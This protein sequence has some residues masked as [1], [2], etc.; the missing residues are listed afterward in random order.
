MKP[1]LVLLL[2][3]AIGITAGLWLANAPEPNTDKRAF[4]CDGRLPCDG[5]RP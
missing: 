5:V 1:L 4:H 3:I 2:A